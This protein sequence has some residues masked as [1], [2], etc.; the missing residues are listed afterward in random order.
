MEGLPEVREVPDEAGAEDG[1]STRNGSGGWDEQT[2]S[3]IP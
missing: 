1:K 3:R 2:S